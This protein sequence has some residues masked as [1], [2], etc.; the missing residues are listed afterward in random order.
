[1][2]KVLIC[3]DEQ[4]IRELIAINLKIAGYETMEAGSADEALKLFLETEKKPDVAVLD[5][6]MPGSMNGLALCKELRK[7]SDYMGIIMLT[8]KV[9]E[10]DKILGLT[11]G[12]DDYM[13]KP[14]SPS[15]LVARVAALYRRVDIYKERDDSMK[16]ELVS[17]EFTIDIKSH[18]LYK[19]N[20]DIDLTQVEYN[21]V[22]Y[23]ME[24][25]GV[26]ISREQLLRSIWGE[27]Y[28]GDEKIVDVNIRRLRMKIED[29]PSAPT[30]L[31]TVWGKGY[32][33]Q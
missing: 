11:S 1:M 13:T 18:K 19:N 12:A 31:V 9:Q 7:L 24:R 32:K 30:H 4:N 23:F 8:A 15:E 16:R 33:W 21:L 3:E 14:F 10:S 2:K 25:P 28:A 17:G 6:M 20:R 26:D 27:T 22:E 29:N 5:I